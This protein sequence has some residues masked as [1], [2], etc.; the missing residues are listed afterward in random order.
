MVRLV[1]SP[2]K[3][4]VLVVGADKVTP[5][6]H[7][8]TVIALSAIARAMTAERKIAFRIFDIISDTPGRS[9]EATPRT[10]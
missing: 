7:A 9:F 6:S 10:S 8:L 1:L 5:E 2:E 3:V 4:T